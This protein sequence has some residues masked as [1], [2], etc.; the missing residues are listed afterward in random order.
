MIEELGVAKFKERDV[1]EGAEV[2]S[3]SCCAKS[4]FRISVSDIWFSRAPGRPLRFTL[5]VCTDS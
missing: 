1:V 2:E 5:N 3:D 4:I